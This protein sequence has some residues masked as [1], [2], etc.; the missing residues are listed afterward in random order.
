M[1]TTAAPREPLTAQEQAQLL[2]EI[3]HELRT[4]LGAA[5][6]WIR[7]FREGRDQA[8]K[9]RALSMFEDSLGE[10]LQLAHDLSDCSALMESRLELELGPISL[11]RLV[12]DVVRSLRP[13]AER[14]GITLEVD[15]DEE[16]IPI[17]ADHARLGRALKAIVGY[18][19]ACRSPETPLVIT[20]R[21]DGEHVMLKVP[22]SLANGSVLQP[23]RDHLRGG[24]S[25]LGPS[26]L[27][28]PVAVEL[29]QLHGGA[30]TLTSGPDE[31]QVV[32]QIRRGIP[33]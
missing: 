4:P 27:T 20:V 10:L 2:R 22:L 6:L 29:I 23:V 5:M 25:N 3:S 9:D 1:D 15:A 24:M 19:I 26:G 7:I 31:D 11:N 12:A 21:S 13:R 30:V 33:G 18:S 8:Q 14:H 28:L 16:E 17:R 32:M